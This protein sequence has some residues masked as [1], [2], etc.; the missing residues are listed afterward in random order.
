ME[1]VNP[2]AKETG[3]GGVVM[4]GTSAGHESIVSVSQEG[5]VGGE[6]SPVAIGS[7]DGTTEGTT[8]GKMGPSDDMG[9]KHAPALV[10]ISPSQP[11]A[12]D[13]V[14][15]A[16]GTEQEDGGD[17]DDPQA[18]PSSPPAAGIGSSSSAA[19]KEL[20]EADG[21]KDLAKASSMLPPSSPSDGAKDL[22]KTGAKG[23]DTSAQRSN[24]T[25]NE[26]ERSGGSD[27]GERTD[28]QEMV[29]G[30]ASGADAD[31]AATAV[32]AGG[33][34]ETDEGGK[35][36]EREPKDE[37]S[38]APKEGTDTGSAARVSAMDKE[39]RSKPSDDDSDQKGGVDVV[40]SG[41]IDPIVNIQPSRSTLP[42]PEKVKCLIK[43]F[44]EGRIIEIPMD[45]E[46]TVYE[47]KARISKAVD[48]PTF[49]LIVRMEEGESAEPL[50]ERE[51]VG[52][53][54][55][56]QSGREAFAATVDDSGSATTGP[57]EGM[58]EAVDH[59]DSRGGGVVIAGARFVVILTNDVD[60][61]KVAGT[62]PKVVL[63]ETIVVEV[64]DAT[65]NPWKTVTVHIQPFKDSK[66]WCGVSSRL[67]SDRA[68][69]SAHR[70]RLL[71][72]H[73]DLSDE[74]EA[75]ADSPGVLY[76]DGPSRSAVELD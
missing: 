64:K 11:R 39:G 61:S 49:G 33:G 57:R 13:L 32:A 8:A 26:N 19:S 30:E 5:E 48:H 3:E 6:K 9:G 31:A 73:A 59:E 75:I 18:T 74:D 76:T 43:L 20:R 71:T 4:S 2:A 25:A 16:I 37:G 27:M 45:G 67:F 55:V 47:L 62:L 66:I 7:S 52:E 58:M 21:A 60:R 28:S 1:E 50:E 54:V 40:A 36:R 29:A 56:R 22:A 69:K 53:I 65:G 42:F 34:G 10:E 44:P 24:L 70:E 35:D 41:V 38:I 14:S 68:E 23:R 46:Q 17:R 63:P 51:R 15:M 12:E 72:G